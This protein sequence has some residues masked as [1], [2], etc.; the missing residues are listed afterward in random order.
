MLRLITANPNPIPV[1]SGVAG[2][3]TIRWNA[4]DAASVEVHVG[5]ATGT[6]FAS[7]GSSGSAQTGEWVVNGMV[8]VLVDATTHAVLSATAVTFAEP[9][10][11]ADPNPIAVAAGIAVGQT[12]IT[13]SAPTSSSVEVHV[14]SATGTL[15]AGG[16]SS[17]S[18]QTGDWVTDGM[19][20]VLVDATTHAVLATTTVTLV[21]P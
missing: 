6:L 3:T 16:G 7:G 20:F 15:F 14:G 4:P 18:A 5:S 12:T 10:I 11:T 13:W 9:T 17:G 2:Q 19:V 8:F 1:F 21:Q